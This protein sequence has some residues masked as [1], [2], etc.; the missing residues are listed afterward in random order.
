MGL[1]K[2]YFLLQSITL[3]IPLPIPKKK[4]KK[5]DILVLLPGSL[6]KHTSPLTLKNVAKTIGVSPS[7]L[8][9]VLNHHP[10]VTPDTRQKIERT[11][12]NLGYTPNLL[13]RDLRLE[14]TKTIRIVISDISNPY[15][16]TVIS[17][18]ENAARQKG[19]ST[20]LAILPNNTNWKRK[21]WN[22]C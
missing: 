1:T 10:D 2:E 19:Y 20:T 8:S 6:P 13:A 16:A 3:S 14:V 11:V 4:E 12:E 18:G 22:S 7:T 21:A 15:F 5:G 9:R 17:G